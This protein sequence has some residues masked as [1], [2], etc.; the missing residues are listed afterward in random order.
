LSKLKVNDDTL[1]V[2]GKV[3][4]ISGAAGEVGS[5]C[6]KRLKDLNANL[7]LFDLSENVHSVANSLKAGGGKVLTRQGDMCNESEVRAFFSDVIKEFGK[8]DG[9][10]NIAAIYKGLKNRDFTTIPLTEWEKVLRVNITGTWVMSKE[11]A[12]FMRKQKNG[13]IINISSTIVHFGA[14]GLLHYVASK[15]AV[16]GMTRGMAQEMGSDGIRVNSIA[17]GVLPTQSTMERVSESWLQTVKGSAALKKL[18]SPED[19]VN[20]IIFLLSDASRSITGQTIVV[21]AGRIFL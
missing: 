2:D 21:D 7:A 20:T 5:V 4:V 9:I 13:S 12:P 15:A 17:P 14:P 11:A 8:L 16:L 3:V 10:V 1:A 19:I 18:A 6:A